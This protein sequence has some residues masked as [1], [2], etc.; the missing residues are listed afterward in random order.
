MG[1]ETMATLAPACT[2]AV[3]SSAIAPLPYA[4]MSR[5]RSR[6]CPRECAANRSFTPPFRTTHFSP[7]YVGSLN[8]EASIPATAIFSTFSLKSA[9]IFWL[10]GE[11][12]S[13]PG[14]MSQSPTSNTCRFGV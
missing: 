12:D 11:H 14:D 9:A 10:T 1:Y 8:S 2:A 3:A 6:D 13:A 7:T 5:S 4:L